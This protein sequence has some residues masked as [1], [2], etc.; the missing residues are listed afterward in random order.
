MRLSDKGK[1]QGLK[2]NFWPGR[3]RP[4]LK[5]CPDTKHCRGEDRKTHCFPQI[6]ELSAFSEMY[7]LQAPDFNPG[8]APILTYGAPLFV[9]GRNSCSSRSH[10][11]WPLQHIAHHDPASPGLSRY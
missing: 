9:A 4:D 3:L 5:S 1:T 8:L 2:P 11:P 10:T 6:L 7:K